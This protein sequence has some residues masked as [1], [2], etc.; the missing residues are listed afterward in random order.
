MDLELQDVIERINA[1]GIEEPAAKFLVWHAHL[2][3][4]SIAVQ[5]STHF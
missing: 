1:N 3:E 5:T 4:H 2:M